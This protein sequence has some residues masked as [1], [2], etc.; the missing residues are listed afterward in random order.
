MTR[1]R[2]TWVLSVKLRQ[3]RVL[4]FLYLHRLDRPGK[5]QRVELADS[6]LAKAYAFCDD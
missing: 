1:L 6:A 3:C 4:N 5:H 2:G